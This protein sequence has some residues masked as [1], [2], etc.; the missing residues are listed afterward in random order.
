MSTRNWNQ[1]DGNAYDMLDEIVVNKKIYTVLMIS[2]L[3]PFGQTY[4]EQT[5]SSPASW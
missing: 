5:K 3:V 2:S 1:W 4:G